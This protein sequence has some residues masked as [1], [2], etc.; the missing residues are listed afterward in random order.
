MGAL[1]ISDWKVFLIT[2]LGMLM[3]SSWFLEPLSQRLRTTIGETGPTER[4][5]STAAV[6]SGAQTLR[7]RY[8]SVRSLELAL[9]A[10]L[11][12]ALHEIIGE[13][14]RPTYEPVR[15]FAKSHLLPIASLAI[16]GVTGLW[17]VGGSRE[18]RRATLFAS[19][20]GTVIVTFLLC[21]ALLLPSGQA[22]RTSGWL[23]YV[24]ILSHAF[25]VASLG[26]VGGLFVDHYR[27]AT[28]LSL[29]ILCVTLL[30]LPAL[31]VML[32]WY[33]YGTLGYWFFGSYLAVSLGWS[34]GLIVC[35]YEPALTCFERGML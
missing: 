6:M 19:I 27:G 3:I 29:S 23:A 32:S 17:I 13:A 30:T 25:L 9:I 33:S 2:L 24:F 20:G 7:R 5:P 14:L 12:L 15:W 16:A 28:V 18:P 21:L 34:S 10:A 26:F 35:S 11:L 1:G 4:V 22:W 31:Y 8:F